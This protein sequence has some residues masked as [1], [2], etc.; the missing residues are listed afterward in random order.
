MTLRKKIAATGPGAGLRLEEALEL[1]RARR[2]AVGLET[3]TATRAVY[4]ATWS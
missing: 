2:P 1:S 4:R 3:W